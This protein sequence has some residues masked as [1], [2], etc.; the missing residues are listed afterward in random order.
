MNPRFPAFA[1]HLI[2]QPLIAS[3]LMP[4]SCSSS[5][6]PSGDSLHRL[7]VVWT[8]SISDPSP[9]T[10]DNVAFLSFAWLLAFNFQSSPI[11]T[12]ILANPYSH[13]GQNYSHRHWRIRGFHKS[14]WLLSKLQHSCQLKWRGGDGNVRDYIGHTSKWPRF[15]LYSG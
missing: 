12:H 4:S 9:I 8:K 6:C 1:V 13:W 2:F 15:N 11:C 3:H 10:L 5:S 14:S 7:H